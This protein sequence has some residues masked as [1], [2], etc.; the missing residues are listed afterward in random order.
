MHEKNGL[1]PSHVSLKEA[2]NPSKRWY[3]IRS[4]RVTLNNTTAVLI[5]ART[6]S[7][8]FT[9]TPLLKKISMAQVAEPVKAQP[10]AGV[11]VGVP[12]APGVHVDGGSM[13]HMD[14]E[15]LTGGAGGGGGGG[16]DGAEAGR[17]TT[18]EF[19]G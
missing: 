16:S 14:H 10:V 5:E 6:G 9:R 19:D 4:E 17:W 2:A 13:D 15:P 1:H 18:G 12:V 7:H 11:R 3:Q 8:G